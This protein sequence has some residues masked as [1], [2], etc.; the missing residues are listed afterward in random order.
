MPGV[1][2]LAQVLQNLLAPLYKIIAAGTYLT[3]QANFCDR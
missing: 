3:H 2:A 1:V